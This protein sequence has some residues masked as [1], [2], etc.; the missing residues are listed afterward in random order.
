MRGAWLL[1]CALLG[2]CGSCEP[3]A[4]DRA[5]EPT[6]AEAEAIYAEYAVATEH[7]RAAAAGAEILAAGGN[8]ADAAAATLLALGVLRP[9][10]SG[11]GGGGFALYYRAS[12]R[13][14]THLD[15]REEAPAAA[16]ADMFGED[17][18]ASR[19]GGLS[20]G[21]PGEPAGIEALLERFGSGRV[22]R[23]AVAAPAIRIAEGGWEASALTAH[24][25][26]IFADALRTD[27]VF[28]AWFPDG[29][30]RIPEGARL[31]NPA[32]ARSL[33]AFAEEGAAPFMRGAI[34]RTLVTEVTARRG[35][36]TMDDLAAYEVRA[37][38]PL[39][40]DAYGFT[41]VAPGPP[42]AGGHTLLTSL[43][44]L[45]RWLPT[46]T[47]DAALRHA[48]IESWKGP[49]RD[50]REALGDPDHVDVPLA[51]LRAPA[52]L[53]ARAARFDPARAQPTEAWALPLEATAA[54]VPGAEGGTS[55]VC[56]VDAEGNVASVTTSIN[57]GFGAR[58]SAAG[59]ALNDQLDDFARPGG[60][61]NAFGLRGGAPN[62]PGPG[63]RPVSSATPL[64]VLRDGVPVL[65]AGGSGGSRIITATEQAALLA[66][67]LGR[68]P[69]DAVA[70]R[71]VHHQGDPDDVLV[72]EGLDPELVRGLGARGHLMTRV[73]N[74]AAVQLIRIDED[75]LRPASDART[76]GGVA[77]R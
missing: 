19:A 41:W 27:A 6:E 75:G 61:P 38:E 42:S 70:S 76:T 2:G 15:F 77:G 66:L 5:P 36:L 9:G 68:S 49:Y 12:D 59:Y 17:P 62:L 48:L 40:A 10:S 29:E 63:R 3:A 28:G 69:A 8:A 55:H 14:L 56:V 35:L 52:R 1:L 51:R 54:S 23:R 58:F 11:L 39:R 16:H 60:E 26:S 53:D 43:A 73:S 65:C 4:S 31:T 32:L 71:R 34:A 18:E 13:S 67:V 46:P 33:R 45:E 50:R 72:E 20:V 57:L 21:V 22:D 74:L 30:A 25:A 24:Y 64:I 37:R 47:D 7:P 44:L